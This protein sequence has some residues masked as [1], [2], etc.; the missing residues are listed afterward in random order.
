MLQGF[1]RNLKHPSA[2]LPI[3]SLLMLSQYMDI[4]KCGS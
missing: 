2:Y 3:H 4:W 1:V